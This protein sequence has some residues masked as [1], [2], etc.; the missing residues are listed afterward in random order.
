[1]DTAFVAAKSA[2]STATLL[3]HPSPVAELMLVTDASGTHVG[4]VL[5]QQSGQQAW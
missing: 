1:M 3:D 5:Q 2:L 4:A